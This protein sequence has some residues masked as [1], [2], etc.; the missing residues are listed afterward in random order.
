MINPSKTSVKTKIIIT[1]SAIWT[2]FSLI[3][4]TSVAINNDYG[5]FLES[6]KTV[7]LPIFQ[8]KS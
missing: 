4:S 2:L 1:I 6:I 3:I 8:H 5:H 7:M